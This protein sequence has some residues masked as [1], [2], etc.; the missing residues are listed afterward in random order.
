MTTN[1]DASGDE[2]PLVAAHTTAKKGMS[3]ERLAQLA[4]ARK[5]AV[6]KRR[7]LGDITRREKELKEREL[8]ERLEKVKAAEEQARAPV[9]KK[10]KK[11]LRPV[12]ES[13]DEEEEEEEEEVKPQRSTRKARVHTNEELTAEVAR[14]ELQRRLDEQTYKLAYASIFPGHRLP[15]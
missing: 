10:S 5:K 15:M 6:E 9:K 7:V 4:E 13:D 1:S 14:A 12:V 8:V 2:S 3:E 11:V